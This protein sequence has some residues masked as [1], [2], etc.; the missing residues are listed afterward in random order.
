MGISGYKWAFGAHKRLTGHAISGA[1]K[2]NRRVRLNESKEERFS[3]IQ[4]V[5]ISAGRHG[6]C[7]ASGLVFVHHTLT[8]SKPSLSQVSS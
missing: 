1:R 5:I 7:R 4:C 8:H 6:D 2:P 3:P